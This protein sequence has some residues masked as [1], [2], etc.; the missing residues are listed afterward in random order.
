M[1]AGAGSGPARNGA[2]YDIFDE[3]DVDRVGQ[4]NFV[5]LD[6]KGPLD[7][8]RIEIRYFDSDGNLLNRKNGGGVDEITDH[9]V[10]FANDLKAPR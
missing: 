9:S 7:N 3:S 8:R 6:F 2:R 10:L 4:R 1:T 5:T